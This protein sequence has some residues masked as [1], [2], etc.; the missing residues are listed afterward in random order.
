MRRLLVNGYSPK[1]LESHLDLA[2]DV[3]L[4]AIEE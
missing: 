3:T 2:H 4:R 1:M